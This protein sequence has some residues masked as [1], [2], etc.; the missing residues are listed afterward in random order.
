MMRSH[1]REAYAMNGKRYLLDTNAI[2]ALLNGHQGLVTLLASA[3]YVAISVISRLEFLSFSGITSAQ[4]QLFDQF[5]ARV[6][7]VDLSMSNLSL[8]DMISDVRIHSSLKLPDAIVA[9]SAKNSSATL[10]T[11]DHRLANYAS[12]WVVNFDQLP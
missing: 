10:V 7:V 8:L 3:D 5:T 2:I 9:A 11:A 1:S 4:R 6:D 12:G